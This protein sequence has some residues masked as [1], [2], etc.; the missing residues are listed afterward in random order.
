MTYNQVFFESLIAGAYIKCSWI[1]LFSESGTKILSLQ[2][3][4]FDAC[5]GYTTYSPLVNM[6][7]KVAIT[8]SEELIDCLCS[9]AEIAKNNKNIIEEVLSLKEPVV[10]IKNHCAEWKAEKVENKKSFWAKLLA[11]ISLF[12]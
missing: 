8:P 2:R 5:L 3:S 7:G 6:K 9:Y 4:D 10:Y 11:G 1:E 12:I